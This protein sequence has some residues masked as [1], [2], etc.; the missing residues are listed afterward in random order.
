MD[1]F[2]E[3]NNLFVLNPE[4]NRNPPIQDP[5]TFAGVWELFFQELEPSGTL[6]YRTFSGAY[7]L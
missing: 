2:Q 6:D 4:V 1:L 3:H 7:T 5:M